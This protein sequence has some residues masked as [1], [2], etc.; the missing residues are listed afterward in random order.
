VHTTTKNQNPDARGKGQAQD[1]CDLSLSPS[2]FFEE[3]LPRLLQYCHSHWNGYGKDILDEAIATGMKYKYMTFSLFTRLCHDAARDLK[4]S[5]WQHTEKGTIILPP[6][7]RQTMKCEKCGC[8][9][10]TD[11]LG[12]QKMCVL[13]GTKADPPAPVFDP[14]EDEDTDDIDV[15]KL[16]EIEEN[17][18]HPQVHAVLEMV[19]S[20]ENLTDAVKKAE[21]SYSRF[22]KKA[23]QAWVQPSLFPRMAGGAR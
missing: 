3:N 6:T 23:Y 12:Y 10:F 16:Q 19:M 14:A 1:T 17:T 9:K 7:R 22:R 8:E 20:G 2:Q 18:L 15:E 4:I 21:I 11:A 5:R 13:C